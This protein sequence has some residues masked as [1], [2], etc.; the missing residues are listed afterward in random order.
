MQRLNNAFRGKNR[1]TDVLSFDSGVPAKNN[2]S[3]RLSGFRP[4]VLGDIVVNTQM[5]LSRALESGTDI[6][7]EI[8]RI[9]IHGSLHLLGYDHKK[10][11]DAVKMEKKEEEIFNA[12]KKAC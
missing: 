2:S 6:Y 12:L 7:D 3:R 9:L 11:Y 4:Y 5:V 1:P 8:Y 10:R